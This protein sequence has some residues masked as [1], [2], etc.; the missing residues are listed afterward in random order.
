MLAGRWRLIKLRPH[1]NSP[2][3]CRAG[4]KFFPIPEEIPKTSLRKSRRRIVKEKNM[5][6]AAQFSY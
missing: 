1:W 2:R 4:L 3:Q 6:G 5:K